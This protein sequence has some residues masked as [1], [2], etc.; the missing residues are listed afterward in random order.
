[1][2]DLELQ[3]VAS[4]VGGVLLVNRVLLAQ[5][6]SPAEP[7]VSMRGL[8]LPRVAGISV[9]VGDPVGLDTLRGQVPTSAA[10]TAGLVPIPVVPE[11]C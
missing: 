5:G 3:A 6:T 11:E 1:M 10:A 8:E 2:A 7:Q 9:V 4:R